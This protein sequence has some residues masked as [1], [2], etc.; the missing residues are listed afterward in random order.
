MTFY[1]IF[2]EYEFLGRARHDTPIKDKH[3]SEPECLHELYE[4]YQ[5]KTVFSNL[6]NR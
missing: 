4:V 3:F 5:S 2:L 6:V 1:T